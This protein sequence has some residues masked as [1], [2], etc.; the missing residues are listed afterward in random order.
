MS[1]KQALK[2][3]PS[4]GVGHIFTLLVAVC[5]VG[6]GLALHC[7]VCHSAGNFQTCLAS[8]SIP[9][10]VSMVNTTHLF[11][12]GANPTLRNVTYPPG[13][14]Q[15][16]CFQVNYTVASGA[17][18]Y[19]MGCTFATTKICEGWRTAAKCLT[20]ST[21]MGGVPTRR[22]APVHPVRAD[23]NPQGVPVVI[24]PHVMT[25]NTPAPVAPPHVVVLTRDHKSGAGSVL[26][27]GSPVLHTLL[28]TIVGVW[29]GRKLLS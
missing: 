21:N 13:P 29:V 19:E 18:N 20:V 28:S 17:W 16:Q 8:P 4:V 14:P 23:Y 1:Y 15:Y 6:S 3:L 7:R 12:S 27:S 25:A 5:F 2:V 9:C 10:S 22:K 11:L 24:I 26:L